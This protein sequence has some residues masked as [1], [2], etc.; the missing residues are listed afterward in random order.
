MV[1]EQE[2]KELVIERL[3][4]LPEN[5]GMSIG[6]RGDFDREEII[7][8]VERGDDIGKKIIEAELNFLRGLKEGILYES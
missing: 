3:K 5:T 1:T 2:I 6:S 7:A 8:H 4:T